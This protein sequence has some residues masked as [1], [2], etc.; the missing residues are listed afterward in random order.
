MLSVTDVEGTLTVTVQVAVFPLVVFAVITAVPFATAVITP[1]DETVATALLLD[2]YDT[3]SV[4]SDGV[5]VL[6]SEYVL[7]FATVTAVLFS[8]IAVAGDFTVTVQ[9]N[10]FVLVDT[11]ISAVP[12]LSAVITP[13]SVTDTTSEPEVT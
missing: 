12:G 9:Y 6:L 11:I 3:L 13:S 8:F 7:P 5:S 10:T 4:E 2:V 1:F